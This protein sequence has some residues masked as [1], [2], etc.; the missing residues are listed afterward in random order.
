MRRKSS[1]SE[2]GFKLGAVTGIWSVRTSPLFIFNN[3][4][5]EALMGS[6]RP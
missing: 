1:A 2:R 3:N 5:E 4:A 6:S